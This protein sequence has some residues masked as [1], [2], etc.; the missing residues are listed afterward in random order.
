MGMDC[1]RCDS[2]LASSEGSLALRAPQLIKKSSRDPNRFLMPRTAACRKRSHA[3]AASVASSP[4]QKR[5][6]LTRAGQGSRSSSKCDISADSSDAVEDDQMLVEAVDSER[7]CIVDEE[8]LGVAEL[9]RCSKGKTTRAIERGTSCSL[10][11][12]EG[13]SFS[14]EVSTSDDSID[15]DALSLEDADEIVD[16]F[17]LAGS[18]RWPRERV[19]AISDLPD[20]VL[21]EIFCQLPLSDLLGC[22]SSVCQRWKNV[23][24]NPSFM[25]WKKEYYALKL[26]QTDRLRH[27]PAIAAQVE[28]ASKLDG[29]LWVVACA[30]KYKSMSPLS[31]RSAQDVTAVLRRH[32]KYCCAA[33]LLSNRFSHDPAMFLDAAMG[34]PNPWALVASL[35]LLA[36]STTDVRDIITC[37]SV[38]QS[39]ITVQEMLDCLYFIACLLF[40][41]H[42]KYGT[43]VWISMHYRLYHCLYTYE[44][45]DQSSVADF[46]KALHTT[47]R[48]QQSLLRYCSPRSSMSLTQEQRRIVSCNMEGSQILKVVAF[49]GTGKTACLI[50][51]ARMRPH[52]RFLYI[53]YNKSVA[54]HAEK[55]FPQNVECRTGHSLAYCI[56][57]KRYKRIGD[58]KVFDVSQILPRKKGFSHYTRSK[59]IVDTVKS[60]IAS[61]DPFITTAHVPCFAVDA[62]GMKD[63]VTHE[64]KMAYAEDAEAHWQRM[65]DV[66]DYDVPMTH[67]GYMKLWQLEGCDINKSKVLK[68]LPHIDCLLID[69]AQDMSHALA[70]VLLKQN[71]PK[72]V[73]GDPHQQIYAFRGAVNVMGLFVGTRTLHLTKSFRF[74]PRIGLVAALL[75]D[76]LK[77]VR[78]QTI[79]GRDKED[80]VC[81]S[82]AFVGQVA[83][84]ARTNYYL[85]A[86]AERQCTLNPNIRIHLIG[87]KQGLGFDVIMDIYRLLTKDTGNIKSKLVKKFG[88]IGELERFA[89]KAYDVELLGKIKFVRVYNNRIPSI[90]QLL[91]RRHTNNMEHAE[92]VFATAH[93]A[94]GLEFSTVV[95]LDDFIMAGGVTTPDYTV[96]LLGGVEAVD[97]DERNLLYVAATRAKNCLVVNQST[98]AIS[99]VAGGVFEQ[100]ICPGATAAATPEPSRAGSGQPS[101][102]HVPALVRQPTYLCDGRLIPG[103]PVDLTTAAARR[104]AWGKLLGGQ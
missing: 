62:D 74:G 95:L 81:T 9:P 103:R 27:L 26:D 3:A 51:Y 54:E 66:N 70:D 40:Y 55:L 46:T 90:L 75:L 101:S 32:P 68:K 28:C 59:M 44:G 83:M 16:P 33:G 18:G 57:G 99:K 88:S 104:S 12:I 29:L 65:V 15:S 72:I 42:T 2:Y 41:L 85:L 97:E 7:S 78:R 73:V 36:N 1:T 48:G 17:G 80:S 58:L 14:P 30:S 19:C 49:A 102:R 11:G 20:E 82:G 94:K 24:T 86:E 84:L 5:G 100:P 35:A 67:D 93:K 13:S 39:C 53:V 22:C 69:E 96:W 43:D 79:L 61:S 98:Y 76:Y 50:E 8:V 31:G 37:L 60:F 77:F 23:I 21:A 25:P 64:N 45:L 6:R 34:V 38:K 89:S 56:V 91:E 63:E 4:Q 47:R 87:G 10:R 71:M 92:Y 52:M